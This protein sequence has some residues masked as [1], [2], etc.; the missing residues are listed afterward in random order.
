M[1]LAASVVA[2]ANSA[3][4]PVGA[5]IDQAEREE[6]KEKQLAAAAS[7]SQPTY[8][9]CLRVRGSRTCTLDHRE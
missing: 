2:T 9:S 3:E 7:A 8:V 6:D 5:V 4:E 1:V